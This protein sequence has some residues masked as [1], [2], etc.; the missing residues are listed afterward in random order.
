MPGVRGIAGLALA[1]VLAAACFNVGPLGFGPSGADYLALGRPAIPAEE[2]AVHAYGLGVWIPDKKSFEEMGGEHIYQHGPFF[3]GVLALTDRSIVFA[4]WSAPER[5]YEARKRIRYGD[6]REVRLDAS[7]QRRL[8]VI[9]KTD[10]EYDAFHFSRL[11]DG[12]ND[13]PATEEAVAFVR[14]RAGR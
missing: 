13:A 4:E 8:L 10:L 5:R 2:G 9:R 6:I 11:S 14:A 3:R 12:I 7:K 1:S